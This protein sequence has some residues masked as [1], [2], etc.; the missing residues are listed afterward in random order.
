MGSHTRNLERLGNQLTVSI[1]AGEDGLTGRQCPIEDCDGYFSIQLGTGLTGDDL[2]CHCPYCGHSGDPADF[3]TPEQ[4]E[5]AK[6]VALNRITGALLKDMKEL[7]FEH[8][9]RPGTFGIG[10]SIKVSG[11]PHPVRYYREK[12][13]ETEVVCEGCTL[14]YAIYGVFAFCPDCRVH[15]SRQILD[16]NFELGMKELALAAEKGGELGDVLIRDALSGTVASFDGYGRET[17]RVHASHATDPTRAAGVSFQNLPRARTVV[18]QL[19]AV[20]LAAGLEPDEWEFACRAFQKRHVV[21]HRMGVVDEAYLAATSDPDA[22]VGRKVPVV[23][24]EVE[25]LIAILRKLST[26]LSD[27]ISRP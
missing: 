2:K 22:V 4:L 5:Y 9:P 1:P 7:E 12:A 6:S 20:D 3:T 21:A 18:Q 24:A 25:R 17:C 10:M 23:A 8:R 14:R 11:Q 13:L 15:N 27:E 26:Y 19:F 16:R